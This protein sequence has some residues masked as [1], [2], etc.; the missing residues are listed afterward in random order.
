MICS[1]IGYR[2]KDL[3]NFLE[4]T[5][6]KFVGFQVPNDQISLAGMPLPIHEGV[7]VLKQVCTTDKDK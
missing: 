6:A 1:L 5:R 4:S 3:D 2:Q 7:N